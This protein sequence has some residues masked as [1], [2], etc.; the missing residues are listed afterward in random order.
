MVAKVS[1]IGLLVVATLRGEVGVECRGCHAAI[2]D[3]Y[4]ETGM[5]RSF[6]SVADVA[7]VE[8]FARRNVLEHAASKGRFT[9][10]KRG[11]RFFIRRDPGPMEK[12]IH[13]VL[14]SGRQARSYV[15]RTAQG[16]LL[17][18]PVTWYADKGGFWGMAPGYDR[19]DHPHFHRKIGFDCMFCHNSYP[20]AAGSEADPK[21]TGALPSGI[22]CSRCH[23]DSARHLARPARGTILN[24]A[25]L[26]PARQN[27]VCMQCHLETTSQPLPA[28]ARVPGRTVFSYD[29]ADPLSNYMLH[30]DHAPGQGF[31]DKFEVVSAAYRMRQSACFLKSGGKMTCVGCHD[32]HRKARAD[33]SACARCH[34][35]L[36]PEHAR[37]AGCASCHMPKRRPEDAPLTWVT[38]HR[39]SRRP[40]VG[41]SAPPSYTGPVVGYYPSDAVLPRVE[42]DRARMMA[43]FPEPVEPR[44]DDPVEWTIFGEALRRGGRLAEAAGALD[45]AIAEDPDVPEA[46][47]NLGV[48]RAAQGRREEAERLFRRALAIDPGNRA[49]R[50][51]L[52]RLDAGKSR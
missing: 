13:Y 21:Y 27:E 3:A 49:A 39:I 1:R 33:D 19:A 38:D 34:G 26:D 30:F 11:G 10:V 46:Y 42:S 14:G 7:R 22:D 16:R 18:M 25:A 43:R 29:P 31:D 47:V 35:G 8:D 24:P 17:A 51:N 37:R 23:G 28:Y 5:A 52:G 41:H 36:P 44:G 9:M 40:G 15:H 48:V 50:G 12:E 2:V 20:S 32:P 4:R 6:R 45:R